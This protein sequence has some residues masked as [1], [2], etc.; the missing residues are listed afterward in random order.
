MMMKAIFLILAL[1]FA[2]APIG[3]AGEKAKQ[4]KA[5]AA[6]ARA[7]AKSTRNQTAPSA[8]KTTLTGSYL[9]EEVRRHGLITDGRSQVLV[10]DND[11]IRNS[12]AV[13]VRELLI[14]KGIH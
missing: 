3:F 14:W 4:K 5:A 2:A 9:K 1:T 11:T 13:D 12:G 10:L 8:E 6:A 7:K